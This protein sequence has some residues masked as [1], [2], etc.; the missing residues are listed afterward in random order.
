MTTSV[1][2]IRD[3]ADFSGRNAISMPARR[4]QC[5]WRR[6]PASFAT[7]SQTELPSL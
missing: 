3:V 4:E 1:V 5:D 6:N 7:F 2:F